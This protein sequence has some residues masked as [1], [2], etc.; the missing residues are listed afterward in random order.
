[1]SRCDPLSI[2]NLAIR[3]ATGPCGKM[4]LAISIDF[5]KALSSAAWFT[6][7]YSFAFFESRISPVKISSLAL[8]TPISLGN[9]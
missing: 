7:P 3:I 6:T 4:D 1:M 2:A 9:L 5:S 8:G